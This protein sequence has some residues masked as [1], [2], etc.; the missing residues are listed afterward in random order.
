MNK[1]LYFLFKKEE[2]KRTGRYVAIGVALA[3]VLIAFLHV[4][5][6]GPATAAEIWVPVIVMVT[7]VVWVLYAARKDRIRV[8]KSKKN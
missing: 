4:F 5:A 3:I 8:N 1:L 7:Y 2:R 6:K